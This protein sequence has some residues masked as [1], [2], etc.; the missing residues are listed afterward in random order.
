MSKTR[1][2]LF[3][4]LLLVSPILIKNIRPE[5]PAKIKTTIT[6]LFKFP[7]H[8]VD[9]LQAGVDGVKAIPS[10]A[11][12]NRKLEEERK[13]LLLRIEQLEEQELENARLRRLL[14]FGKETQLDA[15]PARIIARD[16]TSWSRSVVIDRGA[17]DGV[18]IDRPIITADGLV[19]KVIEVGRSTSKVLLI[20]DSNSRIS[21]L[22]QRTR[23]EGL[24][25]GRRD[26]LCKIKYISA[27]GDVALDDI[28]ITSGTG[29]IYPK[30]LPI[31]RIIEIGAERGGLYKYAL[32]KPAVPFSR[33]EEVLCVE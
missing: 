3:I 17:M 11:R 20:L 33:L 16:P 4:L 12:R 23:E 10:L 26:G 21:C 31:G 2:A 30:G 1:V 25:E 18:K 9:K 15:I 13:S 24:L 27:D 14:G 8:I 7:L 5:Y 22:I 28:V 32:V 29:G 19:G 6:G